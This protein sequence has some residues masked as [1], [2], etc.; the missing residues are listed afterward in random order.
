MQLKENLTADE[1]MEAEEEKWQ[2]PKSRRPLVK[3][4][5]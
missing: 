5:S 1:Q 3:V 4:I 2:S